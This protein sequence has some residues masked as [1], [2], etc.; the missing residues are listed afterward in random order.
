MFS[1]LKA[2]A[3]SALVACVL[4]LS[5]CNSDANVAS[6]NIS[7]AAGNFEVQRTIMF[8]NSITDTIMYTVEGR[9]S[10]KADTADNEL[11]VT[12]KIAPNEFLRHSL[13][14]ADNISYMVLQTKT[15]DVNTYHHRVI[16]K[17]QGFIPDVDFKFDGDQLKEA[18]VPDS[19]DK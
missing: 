15:V 1:K 19:N 5:G 2:L 4:V 17:P 12:C 9:C 7:K 18:V 14:L 16:F 10:T 8:Y 13:G 3:T 11:E 6:H